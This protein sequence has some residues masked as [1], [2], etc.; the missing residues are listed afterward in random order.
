MTKSNRN[1]SALNAF[2]VEGRPP[3]NK[4]H[5]HALL[6]LWPWSWPDGQAFKSYSTDGQTQSRMWNSATPRVVDNTAEY[7]VRRVWKCL[8][9]LKK[10]SETSP[11]I[12]RLKNRITNYYMFLNVLHIITRSLTLSKHVFFAVLFCWDGAMYIPLG[13]LSPI[14]PHPPLS[15]NYWMGCQ[16]NAL[17]FIKSV[18]AVRRAYLLQY[19]WLVCSILWSK[20]PPPR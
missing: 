3:M 7:N 20:V 14:A 13:E 2:S 6:L 11:F 1:K 16:W 15:R 8:K 17:C 18:T 5:G 10:T 12:D 19:L 9:S 4:L